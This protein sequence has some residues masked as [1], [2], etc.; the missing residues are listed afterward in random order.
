MYDDDD[1]DDADDDTLLA[2]DALADV[3]GFLRGGSRRGGGTDRASSS[4]ERFAKFVESDEEYMP[5]GGLPK[6]AQRRASS[7]S[8]SSP[9]FS[10]ISAS[11]FPQ[12]GVSQTSTVKSSAKTKVGRRNRLASALM[13]EEDVVSTEG[14]NLM[15]AA[16]DEL[17][18]PSRRARRRKYQVREKDGTDRIIT[19]RKRQSD[20]DFEQSK[21]MSIANDHFLAGDYPS[22]MEVIKEVIHDAPFAIL[23]YTTL[24]NIHLTMGNTKKAIDSMSVA[25]YLDKKDW[26]MWLRLA[27][28]CI[29][30]VV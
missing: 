5:E 22:A 13:E 29:R 18:A 3:Q 19:S 17:T 23:P 28:L 8:S 9:S 6:Q 27:R 12:E 15:N 25:A 4:L 14:A 1:D 11:V 16:M 20:L 30:Y 24:S 10:S 7:S 2:L 21:K 26:T